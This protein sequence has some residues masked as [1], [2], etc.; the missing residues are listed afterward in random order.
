MIARTC[1][2]L[3]CGA[4]LPAA[5]QELG[6]GAGATRVH[7]PD[8]TSYA[9]FL[10][11]RHALAAH[12]SAMFTYRNEG[13]IPSHH[14]DGHAVQVWY[15]SN[16]AN[17]FALRAGLGPYRYFDTAVAEN[18]TGFENAHGWGALYSVAM[19]WK[20]AGR[21]TWELRA[22]RIHARDSFDS[23]QLTLGASYRLSPDAVHSGDGAMARPGERRYELDLMAGQT[24]LNSFE[25]ENAIARLV[26]L[27]MALAPSLRATVGVLDEGHSGLLDR[28]GVIAQLW[29]E[30]GFSDDRF[31]LGVG[32]GPYFGGDR[33]HAGRRVHALIGTTFSWHFAPAWSARI[34]W[35]RVAS[36][37]DRDSDIVTAG[38][39]YRF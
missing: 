22:D 27:R 38:I 31:T 8:D 37:Y 35:N 19:S 23:T 3:A 30:P 11:Y 29:L 12:W 20:P 16:D 1:A 15:S 7:D 5:A 10:S 24:I 2:I 26:E 32:A 18:P 6:L 28:N 4:L 17:G 34:T 9:W 13:H 36:S 33:D 21:W 25:S 14:R 39:G